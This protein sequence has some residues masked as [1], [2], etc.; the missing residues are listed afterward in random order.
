MDE[1]QTYVE[2]IELLECKR[3]IGSSF[4][5]FAADAMLFAVVDGAV[6]TMAA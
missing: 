5:R 3:N 6:L 1:V 2:R 4:I